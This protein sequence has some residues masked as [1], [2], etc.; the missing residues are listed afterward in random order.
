MTPLIFDISLR[1]RTFLITMTSDI[2]KAFLQVSVDKGD[3]DYLRFLWFDDVFSDTPKIVRNRFAR[4][5]FGVTS[6]PFLL[7]GTIRKHVGNYDLDEQ[8]TQRVLESFYVDD[9]TG[10]E[11]SFEKAFELFKKLKIREKFY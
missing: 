9:F 11:N 7:N 6:S 5:V 4:V 10:G 3:R 2:E 8:F 1:F